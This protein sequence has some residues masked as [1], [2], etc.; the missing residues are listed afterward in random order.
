MRR[1]LSKKGS[2]PQSFSMQVK[3]KTKPFN[4]LSAIFIGFLWLSLFSLGSYF[5]HKLP[6]PIGPTEDLVFSEG[7]AR[8]VIRTLAHD[9]G[10]RVVGSKQESKAIDYIWEQ[11]NEIKDNAHPEINLGSTSSCR[12]DETIS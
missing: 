1:T 7:N 8:Q 3:S 9:I 6:E 2:I 11:L 4:S 10:L 5:Y 12:N